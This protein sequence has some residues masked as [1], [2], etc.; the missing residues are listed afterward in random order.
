[1][2]MCVGIVI[3]I[4]LLGSLFAIIFSDIKRFDDEYSQRRDD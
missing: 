1:M 2:K 3:T 4:V